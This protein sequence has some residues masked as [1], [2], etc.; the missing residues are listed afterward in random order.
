M[1]EFRAFE[2]PGSGW[3]ISRMGNVGLNEWMTSAVESVEPLS[4]T[5]TSQ[6]VPLGICSLVRDEKASPNWTARFLVQI[7]TEIYVG[8]CGPELVLFWFLRPHR[9]V[10]LSNF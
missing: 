4:T 8:R 9:F 7:T 1:P 10:K 6:V 2:M 3:N 5:S